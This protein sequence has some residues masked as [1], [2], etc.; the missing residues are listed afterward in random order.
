MISVNGIIALV[1]LQCC[2]DIWEKVFQ[3]SPLVLLETS[4]GP[5]TGKPSY[6]LDMAKLQCVYFDNTVLSTFLFFKS[7]LSFHSL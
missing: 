5:V 1:V 2:L 7:K 6:F 3:Q 4:Q